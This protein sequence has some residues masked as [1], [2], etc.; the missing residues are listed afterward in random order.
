[1]NVNEPLVCSGVMG[2]RINKEKKNVDHRWNSNTTHTLFFFEVQS[3]AKMVNV[4]KQ[5]GCFLVT[6][7]PGVHL[8]IVVG[9]RSVL[10]IELLWI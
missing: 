5:E 7:P 4:H 1:M 10:V 8:H 9:W 2:V 3:P 6:V